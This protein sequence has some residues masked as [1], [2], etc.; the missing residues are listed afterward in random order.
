MVY[1]AA[2]ERQLVER[3]REF[4]SLTLRKNNFTLYTRVILLYNLM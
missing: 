2:L 1:G 4:E 3:P